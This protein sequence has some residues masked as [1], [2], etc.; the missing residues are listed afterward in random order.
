MK[1]VFRYLVFLAILI[2]AS[3]TISA[4][5]AAYTTNSGIKIGFGS[6][7]SYQTSDIANSAG[8]GFDFTFGS[9]LYQ[10]ENAFLAVDWKFRFLAGE[11]K[12]Y[13]HRINTD[14]T[15]SNIRYSFFNYDFELGLTLNRLREKTRIVL[16]GF[17][18]V[19]ITHGRTFTDLLDA[20]NA[21]YDFTVID[22]GQSKDQIKADLMSLSDNDFETSLSNKAAIMPTAG[23]Y[24]GYQFSRSFTIGIEHKTNFSLSEDNSA[25]G[26]NIDNNIMSGSGIDMNHYT[27]L[28]FRWTIG[29]RSD[30]SSNNAS[31]PAPERTPIV[32]ANPVPVVP[33][34]AAKPGRTYYADSTKKEIGTTRQLITGRTT[35]MAVTTDPVK[36]IVPVRTT[37]TTIP[38]V[39]NTTTS[40]RTTSTTRPANARRTTSTTGRTDRTTTTFTKAPTVK[41]INPPAPLTVDKNLFSLRVQTTNVSK[42]EDVSLVLNGVNNSNFSFSREG[43]VTLN[44]ALKEGQNSIVVSGKNP[45]GSARDNTT[46]SYSPTVIQETPCYSPVVNF[47]LTEASRSDATH[48]LR[49]TVSNVGSKEMIS[50]SFNGT[51]LSNFQFQASSGVITAKLKLNPGTHSIKVDARNECGTDSK[52]SRLTV[53]AVE[54]VKPC[55]VRINP[56]NAAWQF[57]LV[58]SRGSY[59]RDNLSNSNFSYSGSASSLFFK[60]VAGGG[61]AIVNGKPYKLKAGS[62]YLFTGSL[63]VTVSNKNP[64][65]M[66]Q[67]SIC[68]TTNK[69]PVSGNG[70]NRPASP[71]EKD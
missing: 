4:Q 64:G 53:T 67:W 26:I 35:T 14:L 39:V 45:N 23:I 58:T 66:G 12:A 43:L 48:E 1:R 38:V 25:F 37:T 63:S 51:R 19:G 9:S 29:G 24:L 13:D 60:P 10:K 57:C 5:K 34:T 22:D 69:A 18:G 46:I 56:G 49:G 59:N 20:N 50:I 52:T 3:N 21:A 32:H 61:D 70:N 2:A 30:R 17:A 55:G 47:S 27:L 41:F 62:Y 44:I 42:W 6:G 15:Y 16:T 68:I 71:C 54:E 31:Y 40:N 8:F 36:T 28:G 7:V 33:V 65:S 11:N